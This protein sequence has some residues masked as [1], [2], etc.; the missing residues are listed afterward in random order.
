MCC[1]I[2]IL[3][4]PLYKGLLHFG[5]ILSFLHN[6]LLHFGSILS[7]LLIIHLGFILALLLQI[8]LLVHC[9][10]S[11]VVCGLF[12]RKKTGKKPPAAGPFQNKPLC[13][14]PTNQISLKWSHVSLEC[15]CLLSVGAGILKF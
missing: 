10:S 8:A 7:F 5:Y 2:V 9:G 4:W 11:I 1:F 14:G 12:R 6:V 13:I 3:F 15:C